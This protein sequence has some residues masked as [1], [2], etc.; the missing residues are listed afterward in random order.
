[1]PVVAVRTAT[2]SVVP[3]LVNLTFTAVLAPFQPL[4]TEAAEIGSE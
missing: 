4:H 3:E 1:M 2:V